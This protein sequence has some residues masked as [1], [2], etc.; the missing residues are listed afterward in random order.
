M[1]LAILDE[2]PVLRTCRDGRGPAL[3]RPATLQ[4]FPATY[5]SQYRTLV[6]NPNCPLNQ[7]SPDDRTLLNRT[8]LQGEVT[9]GPP[10]LR[11]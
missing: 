11:F 9:S 7:S 3:E 8:A 6:W 2:R 5:T 4:C 10:V 1:S